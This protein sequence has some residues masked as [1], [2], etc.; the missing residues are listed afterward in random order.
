MRE[1]RRVVAPKE[2]G[3][4]ARAMPEIDPF[5]TPFDG[6]TGRT[7]ILFWYRAIACV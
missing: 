7:P 5:R 2:F 6:L 4:G 1:F 3:I